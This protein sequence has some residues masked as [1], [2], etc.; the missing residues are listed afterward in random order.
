MTTMTRQEATPLRF[1]LGLFAL[2]ALAAQ[3]VVVPRTAAHYAA[4]YPEVAHLEHLYGTALV[5]ALVCLEVALLAAWLMVPVSAAGGAGA[6]RPD[7][8]NTVLTTSLGL[9]AVILAGIC[10][11]AG[12]VENICGPAMFLGLLASIALVPATFVLRNRIDGW[13]AH[14]G[15]LDRTS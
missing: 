13:F 7:L 8:W 4:R 11:H 15:S 3:L 9:M 2:I 5:L 12:S 14:P 1:F 6:G 10:F